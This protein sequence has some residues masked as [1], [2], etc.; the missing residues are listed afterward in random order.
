M[1]TASLIGINASYLFLMFLPPLVWLMFYLREDRHPEPKLLL[2]LAFI[3]GMVSVVLAIIGEC[4]FAQLAGQGSCRA[5]IDY[6]GQSAITLFL[7]IAFIEE[8]VKYK[9]AWHGGLSRSA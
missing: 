7:G 9:A 2:L 1:N 5:G 6:I 8:Y 4:A 3:G